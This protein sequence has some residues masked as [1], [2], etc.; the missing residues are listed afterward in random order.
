MKS[1]RNPSFN[2]PVWA[3]ETEGW[4]EHH[5]DVLQGDQIWITSLQMAH[6]EGSKIPL[7]WS[8]LRWKTMI[9]LDGFVLVLVFADC[10][11]KS[12]GRE[13]C[14]LKKGSEVQNGPVKD[15]MSKSKTCKF[16]WILHPLAVKHY[17]LGVPPFQNNWFWTEHR[18]GTKIQGLLALWTRNSD[19]GAWHMIQRCQLVVEQPVRK[20]TKYL[21]LE[22]LQKPCSPPPW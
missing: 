17:R 18:F 13:P 3:D 5:S 2:L 4:N 21:D 1:Y 15:G 22:A 16:R 20:K 14:E 12:S 7:T 19:A 10:K 9:Y 8:C 6:D 11:S